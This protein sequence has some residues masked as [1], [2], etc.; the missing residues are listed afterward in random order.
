MKLSRTIMA[1]AVLMIFSAPAWS[2]EVPNIEH[3]MLSSKRA[4]ASTARAIT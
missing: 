3:T 2:H 1:S 4:M